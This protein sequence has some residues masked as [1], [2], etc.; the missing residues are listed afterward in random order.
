MSFETLYYTDIY[1]FTFNLLFHNRQKFHTIIGGIIGVFSILFFLIVLMIYFINLFLRKKFEVISVLENNSN[2]RIIFN[3]TPL[4]FG[5][6]DNEGNTIF[7]DSKILHISLNYFS[8]NGTFEIPFTNCD[9]YKEFKDINIFNY[10]FCS[11]LDSLTI[12]GKQYDLNYNFIYF[13]IEICQEDCYEENEIEQRLENAIF[14]LSLPEYEINHYNYSNPIKKIYSFHIFKFNPKFYKTYE[15]RYYEID[16]SSDN[17]FL[18]PNIKKN[19]IYSFQNF[20][21]DFSRRGNDAR[22]G[23]IQLVSDSK[24]QRYNRIYVKIQ[25]ILSDIGALIK[26]INT[27]MKCITCF[28]TKKIYVQELVNSIMFK[29]KLKKRFFKKSKHQLSKTSLN[30]VKD[31]IN[32]SEIQLKDLED[33]HSLKLIPETK[34]KTVILNS[35][36][37]VDIKKTENIF[38]NSQYNIQLIETKQRLN[39]LYHNI[40]KDNRF[41]NIKLKWYNY[42]TP[43]FLIK[44]NKNMIIL[45]KCKEEIYKYLNIEK[46]YSSLE[47]D[48]DEFLLELYKDIYNFNL[49]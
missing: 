14:F 26:V 43:N 39:N 16:Y 33:R 4:L 2:S 49:L 44:K 25:D 42:F 21:F 32:P 10:S 23:L 22:I 37:S 31:P 11:N 8:N 34:G 5:F 41:S 13:N 15:F 1:A 19:F 48:K 24:I 12:A 40:I 29:T 18:F 30:I 17:G 28:F 46:I 27:I 45:E 3:N 47:N 6:I 7:N 36:I 20:I 38:N 9:N 35:K